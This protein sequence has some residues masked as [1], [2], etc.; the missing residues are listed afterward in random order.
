MINFWN[1]DHL[2]GYHGFE[3][4]IKYLSLL[5]CQSLETFKGFVDF[6]IGGFGVGDLLGIS[7]PHRYTMTYHALSVYERLFPSDPT[8]G[9]PR[10]WAGEPLIEA[11]VA[12]LILI[13]Y[14]AGATAAAIFAFNRQDLLK[15]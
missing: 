3:V 5:I 10:A 14:G 9:L 11:Q 13:L 15:A 6:I 4:F 1:H 2:F 8:L 7:D 12:L